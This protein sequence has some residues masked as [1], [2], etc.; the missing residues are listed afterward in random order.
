MFKDPNNRDI[1][2]APMDSLGAMRPFVATASD[3]VGA[4]ISEDGRLLA[5]SSNETGHF[6]IYVQRADIVGRFPR[7]TAVHV[8]P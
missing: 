5:Y 8:R 2:I 1:Y 3:E 7:R 6:E 4:T